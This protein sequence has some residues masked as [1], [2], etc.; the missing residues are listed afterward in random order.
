T[1]YP[2]RFAVK[3]HPLAWV[4]FGAG[5]RNCVGMK[6]ALA[7]IKLSLVQLLRNYTVHPSSLANKD[8]ELVELVTI[9]PKQ[10]TIRLERRHQ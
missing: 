2:E 3:R 9:A 1:F 5:P 7:E 8:L 6:F 10:L 4:A